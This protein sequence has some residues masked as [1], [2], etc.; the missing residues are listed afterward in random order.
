MLRVASLLGLLALAGCGSQPVS[1]LPPAA[2]PAISPPL[3]E[4]P[5]GT[6]SRGTLPARPADPGV[7]LDRRA[8]TLTTPAGRAPA[9]IGPTQVIS[10]G[11]ELLY[12]TDTAGGGVLVFHTR[13]ELELTRRVA[14]PGAAP[15]ALALDREHN[16]LWVTLTAT[17]EVA[18]LLGGARPGV[19]RRHRAVRQPDAIAVDERTG[20]V[21]V[22]GAGGVLQRFDRPRTR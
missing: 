4:R 12:V 2:G 22:A 14:L 19:L 9:G 3:R 11:G 15:Y 5:E 18:E 1:D 8:R 6:V 10:D 17:N 21:S 13:P 7:V 16:R 20:G